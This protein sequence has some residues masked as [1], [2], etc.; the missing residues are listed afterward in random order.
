LSRTEYLKKAGVHVCTKAYSTSGM[1]ASDV[2]CVLLTSLVL[3]C[4]SQLR[5][6]GFNMELNFQF[7]PYV[8]S[9]EHV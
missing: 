2:G 8:A 6:R 7:M 5:A 9:R 1:Q 4:A 3:Y